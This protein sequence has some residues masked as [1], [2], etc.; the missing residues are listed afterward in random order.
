MDFAIQGQT[1]LLIDELLDLFIIRGFAFVILR[2]HPTPKIAL[3][4]VELDQLIA[5]VR[6]RIDDLADERISDIEVFDQIIFGN[7][8]IHVVAGQTVQIPLNIPRLII[9]FFGFFRFFSSA[10]P[11]SQ[12]IPC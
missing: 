12:D 2:A 3:L 11:P 10:R 8:Q 1:F 9:L 4:A 6:I 7:P 5:G